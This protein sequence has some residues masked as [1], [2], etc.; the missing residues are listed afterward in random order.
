MLINY[1]YKKA[2]T[3]RILNVVDKINI[4]SRTYVLTLMK[5]FKK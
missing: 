3:C 4:L 2:Y 1:E 5:S